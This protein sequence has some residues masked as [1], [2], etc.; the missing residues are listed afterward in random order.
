[1]IKRTLNGLPFAELAG[2]RAA[3]PLPE[4]AGSGAAVRLVEIEDQS[5]NSHSHPESAEF[6]YV[7]SGEGQ[8][9]QQGEFKAVA[10]GDL[11][12]VP[13]EVHHVTL[14]SPGNR[15]RLLCFFPHP[16]L[17]ANIVENDDEVSLP[18]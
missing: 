2:R 4:A 17:P 9:W 16:D 6:I 11:V 1:M 15:L 13:A 8:H 12:L 14:A 10:A 7:L 3:D 5:R 18:G